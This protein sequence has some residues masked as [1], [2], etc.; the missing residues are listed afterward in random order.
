M[1]S[2]QSDKINE[3]FRPQ[4]FILLVTLV[5]LAKQT[6]S[7]SGQCFSDVYPR[8]DEPRLAEQSVEIN[9]LKVEIKFCG[10]K[11]N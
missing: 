7:P 5:L 2:R 9:K 6:I 11:F 8:P 10:L 4:N 3:I 1:T